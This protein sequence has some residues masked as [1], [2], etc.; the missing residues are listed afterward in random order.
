MTRDPVTVSPGATIGDLARK[1]IDVHIHRVIVVDNNGKP[2]GIVSS[3]DLLAALALADSAQK[4][5]SVT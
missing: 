1:M 2:I 3:T 4:K 5:T